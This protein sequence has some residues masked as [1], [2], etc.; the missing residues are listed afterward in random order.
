MRNNQKY[1]HDD[2]NEFLFFRR[3]MVA[4]NHFHYRGVPNNE[5]IAAIE[6]GEDKWLLVCTQPQTE[7]HRNR[8]YPVPRLREEGWA[9]CPHFAL[10][11]LERVEELLKQPAPSPSEDKEN[12]TSGLLGRFTALLRR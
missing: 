5:A 12:V 11:A 4:P 1:T 9:N 2:G 8:Y 3:H 6:K 7:F 10:D